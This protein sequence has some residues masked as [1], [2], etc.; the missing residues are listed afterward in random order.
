M[1]K[2]AVKVAHAGAIATWA[3]S[4]ESYAKELVSNR[5]TFGTGRFAATELI[6]QALNGR[7]PTAYDQLQDGSR[8]INQ[9]ETIVAREKQQQLKDRFSEWVWKDDD[10]AT[11]LARD[12]NDRFNN[13]R[14]RSFDGS[15]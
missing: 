4:V 5:T 9:Q 14:L 7:V 11:R 12:Y 1:T 3:V 2:S 6:E 8:V 15:T 13:L 10:R